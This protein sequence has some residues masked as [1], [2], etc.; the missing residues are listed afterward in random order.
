MMTDPLDL[1]FHTGSCNLPNMGAGN[2]TPVLRKNIHAFV[3]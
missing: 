1:E 3:G 2:Q